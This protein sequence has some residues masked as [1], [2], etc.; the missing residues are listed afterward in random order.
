MAPIGDSVELRELQVP[1]DFGDLSAVP[2]CSSNTVVVNGIC[3][4]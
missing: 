1:D 3:T 4:V 2:S